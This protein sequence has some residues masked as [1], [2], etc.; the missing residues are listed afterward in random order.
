MTWEG[1]LRE[2]GEGQDHKA[3]ERRKAESEAK[4]AH[5]RKTTTTSKQEAGPPNTEETNGPV[6]NA[7]RKTT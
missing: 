1:P 5:G 3:E 7:Q 6:R 4:M 2:Q